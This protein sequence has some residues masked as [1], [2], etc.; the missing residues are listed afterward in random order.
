VVSVSRSRACGS[1]WLVGLNHCVVFLFCLLVPRALPSPVAL[2]F[3]FFF[4]AQR[5]VE[6]QEVKEAE[7]L[8]AGLVPRVGA[9]L[10]TSVREHKPECT[11]VLLDLV[12]GQLYM[13][14]EAQ[15]KQGAASAPRRARS[16]STTPYRPW[17]ELVPLC[18]RQLLHGGLSDPQHREGARMSM[19]SLAD[20]PRMMAARCL[21][22]FSQ[23][24]PAACREHLL[25]RRRACLRDVVSRLEAIVASQP[26]PESTAHDMLVVLL[27]MLLVMVR[28]NDTFVADVLADPRAEGVLR[29][30][31]R[32]VGDGSQHPQALAQALLTAFELR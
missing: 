1:D 12:Y 3:F 8:D 24:Y 26:S 9:A 30:F 10:H 2:F 31:A 23:V 32:H 28:F 21:Q 6:S 19:Y 4:T 5:M 27:D 13:L 7:L 29:W 14:H 17:A 11:A 15:S 22:L 20:D 18:C 16:D 25:A